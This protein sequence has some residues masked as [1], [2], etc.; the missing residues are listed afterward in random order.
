MKGF[1]TGQFL[2]GT[3]G[4]AGIEITGPRSAKVIA[5]Q[6]L[7]AYKGAMLKAREW[8][9]KGYQPADI[10]NVADD[11][12]LLKAGAAA[13]TAGSAMT[14]AET[15]GTISQ[16]V[17]GAVLAEAVVEL[18]GSPKYIGGNA[19][20]GNALYVSSVTK[21]ADEVVQYWG[22]VIASQENYD[23]Y[24]YGIKGKNYEV[25]NGRVRYLNTDYT[26]FPSWMFKNLAFLRFPAG[27][28]D[29]YI[30]SIKDWDKG[31]VVSPLT[32]FV[33]NP[34]NVTAELAAFAAVWG[35]YTNALSAGT[36]DLDKDLPDVVSKFKASGQDK[37]V[38]EAQKQV[39]EYFA[40]R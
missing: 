16:T 21:R 15:Q 36:L 31:A 3:N 1:G 2:S 11:T 18:P 28:S 35:Q 30:Q 10:L 22:W 9:L 5:I 37:I 19:N 8:Y 14:A 12:S 32:E 23:L 13:A 34:K 20:G 26:N 6:D 4:A 29:S 17:P 7:S 39:D 24:S 33:F 25:D 27:L 38:A 40:G